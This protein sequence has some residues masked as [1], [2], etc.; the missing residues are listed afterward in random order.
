L[1]R[2]AYKTANKKPRETAIPRAAASIWNIFEKRAT[3]DGSAGEDDI[4][5]EPMT[6]RTSKEAPSGTDAPEGA[7]T[8]IFRG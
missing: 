3:E 7:Y 2:K 8:M 6:F 4:G 1:C 5:L